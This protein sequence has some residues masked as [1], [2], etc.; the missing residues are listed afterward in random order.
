MHLQTLYL[1]NFRIY[2][3]VQIEFDPQVNIIH[4]NNALGKTT[5]LEAIYFLISG[6]SF[7]TS[8]VTDLIRHGTDFFYIEAT[9]V[10]YGI[11]QKLKVSCNGPDRK[12]VYNNTVY[13]TTTS[14]FGILQGVIMAPDD[15]SL[16]KGSPTARRH[17]LDLQI[18]QTDPLYVH[19]LTRYERAMRQR[20]C[21]LKAKNSATIESWEIEMA[22]AGAYV[23]QQRQ[24]ATCAL[25]TSSKDVYNALTKEN[26]ELQLCYKTN[27]P[28]V[29]DTVQ[30]RQY[31]L[32]HY[33]KNRKREMD[34]G[35]TL[36]GPHRDDILIEV[37]QKEARY[38]SSEGQ[39]RCCVAALRF[40]EWQRLNGLAGERPLM[41]LDDV[42]LSL[43]DS[44]RERLW[45]YLPEFDQVFLTST[46]TIEMPNLSHRHIDV[47]EVMNK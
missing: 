7:R 4:G 6:R 17:F 29:L 35:C 18:A 25:S 21:L 19:Y 9:F 37:N 10:K 46:Q 38:F 23:V 2:P 33:R 8:Q 32:E 27:G 40:A 13:H 44:R 41:L 45:R 15:V 34:L 39:Q 20:N 30:L 24:N 1:H 12:I 26:E 14:L 47:Q 22:N 16:I 3:E 36:T 28:L 42:G 11:Q 5:I 43:D 31:Y